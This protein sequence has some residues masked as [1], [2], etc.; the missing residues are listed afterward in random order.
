MV[1]FEVFNLTAQSAGGHQIFVHR[2]LLSL[3]HLKLSLK[4]K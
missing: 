4:G 2:T 1:N 3:R